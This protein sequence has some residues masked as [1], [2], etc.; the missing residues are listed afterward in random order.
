MEPMKSPESPLLSKTPRAVRNVLLVLLMVGAFFFGRDCHRHQSLPNTQEATVN[1]EPIMAA[2]YYKAL[3]LASGPQV[4]QELIVRA[5]I[6]QEAQ[7]EGVKVDD[8]MAKWRAKAQKE[9]LSPDLI[10]AYEPA[11]STEFMLRKCVLK[12]VSDAEKRQFYEMFKPQLTRWE[13]SHI[14]VDNLADAQRIAGE[15]SRGRAFDVAASLQSKDENSKEKGGRL[16]NLNLAQLRMG[17]GNEA[18]E[19]VVNLAPGTISA[20]IRTRFGYHVF[21]VSAVHSSYEDCLDEVESIMTNADRQRFLRPLLAHANIK[22]PFRTTSGASPSA[23]PSVDVL[24]PGSDR[25][26]LPVVAAPTARPSGEHLVV[27]GGRGSAMPIP[28]ERATDHPPS[29]TRSTSP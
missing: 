6:R 29:D 4:L 9:G 16:G 10:A 1:G 26:T 24:K 3:Q 20:P 14:L 28:N 5:V 7:K 27:P 21:K 17:L 2:E 8:D 11:V 23:L 13:V 25:T 15:V 18:A 12:G 19:A 22:S